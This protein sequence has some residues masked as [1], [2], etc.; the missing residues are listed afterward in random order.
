MARADLDEHFQFH[1]ALDLFLPATLSRME[2]RPHSPEFQVEYLPRLEA[3]KT[4]GDIACNC[5]NQL[6]SPQE[7][8][9]WKAE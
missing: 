6:E 4:P 8:T 7:G 5:A 9:A 2:G 3:V 1:R